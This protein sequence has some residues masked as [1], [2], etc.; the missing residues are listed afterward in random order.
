MFCAQVEGLLQD[1]DLLAGPVEPVTAPVILERRIDVG[2]ES[3]P[4]V[5]LL[6]KYT[7]VYNITG[8]PAISV[9]CGFA[10]DGLPV[11][12]HLAGR[13]FDE[14]TVLKAAYAYQ[15]ANDW[16]TRRPAL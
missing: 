14:M 4:A 5:P 16:H 8:S 6:T 13:N 1:V 11:G 3:L 15:Q 10:E 2:G 9:P 12:L 7:R